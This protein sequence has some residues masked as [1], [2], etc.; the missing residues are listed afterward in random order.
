MFPWLKLERSRAK[1]S[2]PFPVQAA[3]ESIRYV[4][5]DTEL[6]SLNKRSNR[7]LSIGAI[8]MDGPRIRLGEQFYRVVNSGVAVPAETVLIHKLRPEDVANGEPL[9]KALDELRK[10]VASAVL[11]GHF[12]GIDLKILRK[13]MAGTGHKLNNPAVDT[14]RM[15]HWLLRQG[16]YTEDLSVRLEKLDL[17]SVAK[18]HG[19]DLEDPHH[20]LHDAFLTARVWQK[21]MHLAQGKGVRTLGD[22]LRIAGA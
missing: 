12:V 5:L 16:R 2:T 19:L 1:S 14:A 18:T 17:E 15:H 20:A 3:L 9:P 10:F 22:L 6:T 7:L 11:V 8:A 4:V 21:M 13:E